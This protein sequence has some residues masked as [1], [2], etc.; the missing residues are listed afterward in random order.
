MFDKICSNFS[1]SSFKKKRKSKKLNSK[2]NK[3]SSNSINETENKTVDYQAQ[4]ES[5][6]FQENNGKNF[7]AWH[8]I[9]L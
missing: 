9:V 8:L 2:K 6:K 7:L 4:R 5:F 1:I 3:A